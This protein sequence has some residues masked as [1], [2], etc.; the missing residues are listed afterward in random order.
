M[1]H[2]LK[3]E[4]KVNMGRSYLDP[5]RHHPESQLAVLVA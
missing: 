3:V 4:A 2:V 5:V 1:D